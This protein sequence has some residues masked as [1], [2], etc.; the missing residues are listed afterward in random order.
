MRQSILSMGLLWVEAC[1]LAQRA[2]TLRKGVS[3]ILNTTHV[4]NFVIWTVKMLVLLI[5]FLLCGLKINNVM[6][7]WNMHFFLG[8]LPWLQKIH[9]LCLYG[10]KLA[11]ILKKN[12]VWSTANMNDVTNSAD[13]ELAVSETMPKLSQIIWHQRCLR[14]CWWYIRSI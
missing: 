10:F 11:Y 14:L 13:A 2:T 3:F 1:F 6:E 12:S 5:Y 4:L 8:P 7:L 9:K